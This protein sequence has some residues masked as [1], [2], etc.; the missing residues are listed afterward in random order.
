MKNITKF[1]S[2]FLI[3]MLIVLLFIVKSE[4]DELQRNI[5]RTFTNAI[6]DSMSGLSKDYSKLSTDEKIQC[7]YQTFSNLKDAMEVFHVSSYKE[8]DNFFQALNHLYIYLLENHN[9]NYEI[10]NKLFIFEFLGKVLVYPND[11]QLIS[12]FN[13][14]LNNK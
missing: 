14:S 3:L 12:D 8:Y 13:N 11:E 4:K 6:S 2:P 7:Y 9:E 1:L 10:N 5:D